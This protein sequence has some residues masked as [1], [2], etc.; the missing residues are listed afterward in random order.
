MQVESF[1]LKSPITKKWVI[2]RKKAEMYLLFFIWPFV[3]FLLALR[4]YHL[5]V[6][7][8]IVYLFLV[9]YGFT[10]I[11]VNEELDS[12][13][14]AAKLKQAAALPFT[15][16]WDIIGGIYADDTS[17]DIIEPFIR[18]SVSRVTDHPS[19]LFAV[20]ALVFGYFYL[21]SIDLFY[22][23]LGKSS[24]R[25]A[26]VYLLFFVTIIPIFF[27]NGFRFWTASWLFFYGAYHVVLLKERD[28]FW[29]SMSACL[30]H[31]SF[32]SA[33]AVLL[34]YFFLGN[35]NVIYYPLVVLSFIVP[36]LIS[37]YLSQFADILGGGLEGRILGYTN[38]RYKTA[39]LNA[40]D[41][42][43]WFMQWSGNLV[44]YYLF[45]AILFLKLKYLKIVYADELKN[46]FSFMLFFL[47]FVNFAR[48]IPSFGGRFQSVFFLFAVLYIFI[49]FTKIQKRNWHVVTLIGLLPMAL[50][51]AIAFRIGTETL[52]F[53]LFAPTPFFFLGSDIALYDLIKDMTIYKF[54]F[55]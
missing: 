19:L 39:V 3:A 36:D 14:Y 31:F 15:A 11:S 27:I 41:E 33:N 35:R 52:N 47:S 16:F 43:R 1:A 10:F 22:A 2:N 26:L 28:F 18:F 8:N 6:S 25:N 48:P 53:I 17:V 44:L 54:F 42:T 24:N 30:V 51:A 46:L 20:F 21:N 38:V 4:Q 13:R 32:L 55:K 40:W 7:R 34:I 37:P 45:F 29:V 50:S 9:L 12:Y 5:K 23:R 49:V